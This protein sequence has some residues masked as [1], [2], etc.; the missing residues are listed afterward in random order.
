MQCNNTAT[1]AKLGVVYGIWYRESGLVGWLAA[2]Y[3]TSLAR[4]EH[5]WLT[6][7]WVSSRYAGKENNRKGSQNESENDI[8]RDE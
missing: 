6:K 5:R 3:F 8:N 1:A 7:I 4:K 2:T